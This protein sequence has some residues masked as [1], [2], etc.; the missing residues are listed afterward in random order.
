LFEIREIYMPYLYSAPRT[1]RHRRNFAEM[2]STGK[3]RTIGLQYAEEIMMIM[4]SRYDTIPE[5]DRRTDGRTDGQNCCMSI[6]RQ[7]EAR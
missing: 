1:R 4:L 2:F 7:H 6:A 5:R 3:T